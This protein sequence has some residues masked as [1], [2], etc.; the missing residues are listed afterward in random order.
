MT[1]YTIRQPTSAAVPIIVSVPHCGTS[2]PEDL[3][4][5]YNSNLIQR[6]DDTD[7]FVHDLY[8]FAGEMGMT[9]IHAEF[10]RWVV[11]LNRDPESKPL[12]SDGRIITALC[13]VTSFLGE[14]LYK[15]HR[16]FVDKEEANNR[17]ARFYFPYHTALRKLMDET[18]SRFGKVLL[19]DCHSIRHSVKTIHA[20]DFPDLNLGDNDGRSAAAQLINIAKETLSSEEYSFSHNYPFKG[21][22]ITRHFGNPDRNEFALQLE[23]NKFR[24]MDDDEVRYHPVRAARMR[25]LLKKT[26]RRLIEEL[27][28]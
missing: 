11:D 6:P 3:R 8:D 15:D 18:K 9:L 20:Q 17:L 1:P 7:W 4:D 12:Y 25:E 14:P 10:S 22:Y 27:S 16:S 23:M 13:P 2:F 24:Y 26:F 21:G 28:K 19:W 5:Q